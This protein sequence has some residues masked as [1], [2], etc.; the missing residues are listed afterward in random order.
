[1][2]HNVNKN[3]TPCGSALR[4]LFTVVASGRDADVAEVERLLASLHNTLLRA[5]ECDGAGR[6]VGR[7]GPAPATPHATDASA[8]LQLDANATEEVLREF[9][10]E[11]YNDWAALCE[12]TAE[13]PPQHQEARPIPVEA[14]PAALQLLRFAHA[15]RCMLLRTLQQMFVI[16]YDSDAALHAPVRDHVVMLL[17]DQQLAERLR[18]LFQAECAARSLPAAA[19]AARLPAR[20][21]PNTA[22]AAR[23]DD[24]LHGARATWMGAVRA[25][26]QAQRAVECNEL[27]GVLLLAE[28]AP[29]CRVESIC[30]FAA[31]QDSGP[32]GARRLSRLVHTLAPTLVDPSAA[33]EGAS[34][35]AVALRA[36][37]EQLAALVLIAA[38]LGELRRC[39][40]LSRGGAA[41]RHRAEALPL[42]SELQRRGTTAEGV[43]GMT[44]RHLPTGQRVLVEHVDAAAQL[45][46]V[47]RLDH[48]ARAGGDVIETMGTAEVQLL[49]VGDCLASL[50]ADAEVSCGATA[51]GGAALG[52]VL[53]AWCAVKLWSAPAEGVIPLSDRLAT[54]GA[55]LGG[56][57]WPV[58]LLRSAG[59]RADE[60]PHAIPS[61][62]RR[63]VVELVSSLVAQPRDQGARLRRLSRRPLESSEWADAAGWAEDSRTSR[64]LSLASEAPLQLLVAAVAESPSLCSLVWDECDEPAP[65]AAR[66]LAALLHTHAHEWKLRPLESWQLPALLAA[67]CAGS[68][69]ATR[70]WEM[71]EELGMPSQLREALRVL[72]LLQPHAAAATPAVRVGRAA[73]ALLAHA[74][75]ARGS[76]TLV[77]SQELI[78]LLPVC[79]RLDAAAALAGADDSMLLVPPCAQLLAALATRASSSREPLRTHL[80]T[81]ALL[82]PDA[83]QWLSAG[84]AR[85]VL[86][87]LALLRSLIEPDNATDALQPAPPALRSALLFVALRLLPAAPGGESPVLHVAVKHAS[88]QL[89]SA[90]LDHSGG[91][92]L[93]PGSLG[94]ELVEPLLQAVP[95]HDAL[96]DVLAW[97]AGPLHRLSMHAA[98]QGSPATLATESPPLRAVGELIT[99]GL[100]LLLRLLQAAHA[101]GGSC[102]L[103]Q[104][105]L[106]GSVSPA[107]AERLLPHDVARGGTGVNA[108]GPSENATPPTAPKAST[109]GALRALALCL[110]LPAEELAGEEGAAHEADAGSSAGPLGAR[111][112]ALL[113]HA[114]RRAPLEP[115]LVTQLR[116]L[117]LPLSSVLRRWLEAALLSA[118]SEP[119]DRAHSPGDWPDRAAAALQ[120][121]GAAAEAQPELL[122][123]LCRGPIRRGE[124]AVIRPECDSPHGG[125]GIMRG[126]QAATVEE[127]TYEPTVL[128]R[129]A[130]G[131]QGREWRTSRPLQLELGVQ[132][133]PVAACAWRPA[134]KLHD[135]WELAA[136]DGGHALAPPKATAAAA[137][138]GIGIGIG[139]GHAGAPEL[140]GV[141]DAGASELPGMLLVERVF[142]ARSGRQDGGGVSQ[143][144]LGTLAL[145]VLLAAW[146]QPAAQATL[147][148]LRN[149]ADFWTA[150]G[151]L[152]CADETADDPH[153]AT[154]PTVASNTDAATA[155]EHAE[156]RLSTAHH[157]V[158]RALG[159]TI[160]ASE[161]HRELASAPVHP[162][163]E[164]AERLLRWLSEDPA[165]IAASLMAPEALRAS[166][167]LQATRQLV[168]RAPCPFLCEDAEAPTTAPV[169]CFRLPRP[170]R[171][172]PTQG[173]WAGGSAAMLH[174]PKLLN[175]EALLV[176]AGRTAESRERAE[177][178]LRIVLGSRD[179]G[180]AEQLA[181]SFMAYERGRSALEAEAA[182]E[183]SAAS[184]AAGATVANAEHT[185]LA[186]HCQAARAFRSLLTVIARRAPAG[187]SASRAWLV[188]DCDNRPLEQLLQATRMSHPLARAQPAWCVSCERGRAHLAFALQL[189]G[190]AAVLRAG[191]SPTRHSGAERSGMASARPLPIGKSRTA[192]GWLES[193]ESRELQLFILTRLL[194]GG[195]AV[196]QTSASS[197][198]AP[199]LLQMCDCLANAPAESAPRGGTATG[200]GWGLQL[201]VLSRLLPALG[202]AAQAPAPPPGAHPRAPSPNPRENSPPPARSS[203]HMAARALATALLPLVRPAVPPARVEIVLLT[204]MPLARATEPAQALLA[205]GLLPLLTTL[206]GAQRVEPPPRSHASDGEE[207]ARTP[208]FRV[209]YVTLALAT[210]LLEATATATGDSSLRRGAQLGQVAPLLAAAR[211]RLVE[212][213]AGGRGQRVAVRLLQC[214]ARLGGLRL[215]ELALGPLLRAALRF[216]ASALPA[217]RQMA[218]RAALA[219][220][221]C[222]ALAALDGA[223][224]PRSRSIDAA[225]DGVRNHTPEGTMDDAPG[226]PPPDPYTA[227]RAVLCALRSAPPAQMREALGAAAERCIAL[228]ADLR[229]QATEAAQPRAHSTV[230]GLQLDAL[231]AELRVWVDDELD[232][233]GD[234]VLRERL[235][236]FISAAF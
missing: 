103:H 155:H 175:V 51:T 135:D 41:A 156:L 193:S 132:R 216:T 199:S 188:P 139:I 208:V 190:A 31:E 23:A 99:A 69:S 45:V 179:D 206:V 121:I 49:G 220:T 178:E 153:A 218:R 227:L 144:A 140:P 109:V 22:G 35:T 26:L 63:L 197:L 66:P 152:L 10:S 143:S 177:R 44:A 171:V 79:A 113:C 20:L 120:L 154:A 104:A 192:P 110:L 170:P 43:E 30:S 57:T 142:V 184:L 8:L 203:Q 12:A 7:S 32:N 89:L 21:R 187:A 58:T 87:L 162:A 108:L 107:A 80:A 40:Q 209:W 181:C 95:A 42:Q 202:D 219:A 90:A 34:A 221:L 72:P 28:Y 230:R 9:R 16:A 14:L 223:S 205:A 198:L 115:H 11:A 62:A 24:P 93:V 67:L 73:L 128:V 25:E 36:R 71:A 88:F 46:T 207:K 217:E 185:A 13:P 127:V 194:L 82:R 141:I 94:A 226:E 124:A 176:R 129:L 77:P 214:V 84:H 150:L 102:A 15:S 18:A 112:L 6:P 111:C 125:W 55:S 38:L 78:A 19:V 224:L 98:R 70:T 149:S 180:S 59:F 85:G 47:R 75:E 182:A 233:P 174:V 228:A 169:D 235:T 60:P 5:L 191:P 165:R 211:P 97:A 48:D 137:D 161:L 3:S 33:T 114:A 201:C 101:R 119:L 210:T 236:R 2:L 81:A 64:G 138:A 4:E 29:I 215:P 136:R 131:S 147:G 133:P 68:V 200:T 232:D 225:P 172:P 61:L 1:M 163:G 27:L 86:S 146:A 100:G 50:A 74:P 83:P 195:E 168:L 17:F 164:L 212:A 145:A 92:A 151:E 91:A 231:R 122:G 160:L 123:P 118:T 183:R 130:L 39:L 56:L 196:G 173:M 105:L 126:G 116:P 157:R 166:S 96:L 106:F 134:K 204:L 234:T 186:A 117:G 37:G 189:H 76:S 53:L 148:A 52:T 158:A 54:C 213:V 229:L 167:A 222:A 65:I 159:A